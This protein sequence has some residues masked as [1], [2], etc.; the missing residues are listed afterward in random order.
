[1]PWPTGFGFFPEVHSPMIEAT[2][3]PVHPR[4][5]AADS[6]AGRRGHGMVEPTDRRL[7]SSYRPETGKIRFAP[8]SALSLPL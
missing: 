6:I 8:V 3:P 1:L 7:S 2:L 5:P 4:T